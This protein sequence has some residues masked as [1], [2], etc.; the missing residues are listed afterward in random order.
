MT[1]STQVLICFTGRLWW[2]YSR[3][4]K[5]PIFVGNIFLHS[6]LHSSTTVAMIRMISSSIAT[7]HSSVHQLINT[8]H[9]PM[10]P[11]S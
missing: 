11:T 2:V 3:N 5:Y 8:V 6:F 9:S 10:Y 4:G 7:S 1:T